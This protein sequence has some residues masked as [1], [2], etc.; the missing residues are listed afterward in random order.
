MEHV[1]GSA[2]ISSQM[3]CCRKP[4]STTVVFSNLHRCHN[5][6][7]YGKFCQILGGLT[8][9]LFSMTN[10]HWKTTPIVQHERN[11]FETTIW[12]L[13][14]NTEGVQGP[15]NQLLDFVEA[16]TRNRKTA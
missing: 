6:D 3:K 1:C 14:L 7:K 2:C 11:A 8:N 4:A 12:V 5:D 13:L 9:R 15:L 10:L 16:K